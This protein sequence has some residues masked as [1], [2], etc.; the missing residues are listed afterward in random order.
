MGEVADN[1]AVVGE[2][3]MIPFEV[4]PIAQVPV[5]VTDFVVDPPGPVATTVKVLSPGCSSTIRLSAVLVDR[6]APLADAS[7]AVIAF[8][9]V[10]FAFVV[11]PPNSACI[12]QGATPIVIV[13]A[14][15]ATGGGVVFPPPPP[16]QAVTMAEMV[17]VI[18]NKSNFFILKPFFRNCKRTP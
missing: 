1:V 16:P 6:M 8:M 10:K 14:G 18:S 17:T 11:Q 9:V 5:T 13:G 2:T 4:V 12:V 3:Q 7:V 15:V